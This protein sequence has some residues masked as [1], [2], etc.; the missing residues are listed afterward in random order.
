MGEVVSL[1]FRET[2]HNKSVAVTGTNSFRNRLKTALEKKSVMLLMRFANLMYQPMKILL[3][4][5]YLLIFQP[6][7]GLYLLAETV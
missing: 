4:K 2:I 5:M 1:D 6:M 3:L 7:N